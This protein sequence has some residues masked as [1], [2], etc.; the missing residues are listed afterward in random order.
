MRG[1]RG[2]E[3]ALTPSALTGGD[4][5]GTARRGGGRPSAGGDAHRNAAEVPRGPQP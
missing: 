4:E 2:L 3:T 1:V 5:L